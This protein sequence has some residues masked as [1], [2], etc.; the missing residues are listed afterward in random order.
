[1]NPFLRLVAALLFVLVPVG[2]VQVL[3]K[4]VVPAAS[5]MLLF[6]D[7]AIPVAFLA[8]VGYVRWVERRD[9]TEVALR[10][11]SAEFGVG[12]LVGGGLFTAAVAV[13]WGLGY[14]HVTGL[15]P[16]NVLIDS[17]TLSVLSGFLE[18]LITRGIIFRILE[19]VVG[20]WIALA[21]SALLFGA[22]HLGN[23]NATWTSAIAIALEAGLLLGA[24]YVLTRRLW[25][26]IGLHLAWNFAQGGI[27]GVAVSGIESKGLLQSTLT[28]PDYLSG[29]A[30]GLEASFIAVVVCVTGFVLVIIKARQRGRIVQPFWQR[31]PG[32]GNGSLQKPV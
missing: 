5:G 31:V 17:L 20:T 23:P 2:L 30:F 18:E 26:A 6:T 16:W 7:L 13:V 28:G 1:M 12:L 27:F 4:L 21:A 29:G 25:L 10:G 8:Y 15:N 32:P 19:E 11:A 3:V 24:C 22:M 9:A 14:Y